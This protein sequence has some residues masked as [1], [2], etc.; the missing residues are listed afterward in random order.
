MQFPNAIVIT[1]IAAESHPVLKQIAQESLERGCHFIVIGDAQSPSD[2]SLAGCD[3]YSLER[4]NQL[5]FKFPR[6]CPTRVYGRKNIGYLIAVQHQSSIIVET[7]DDNIPHDT[8]WHARERTQSVKSFTTAGWVNV[9]RYFTDSAVWPRGFPLDRIQE[10]LAD[11][12]SLP[13]LVADSPIQQGLA[14]EDPD[15][16]AIYRLVISQSTQFRLD[17][18][19]ALLNN[20]WCPFNSQNTTWWKDA[21]P[22]MY[23]P[24]SCSFR[25]TDIWRGFIAQR[26]AWANRW[27]IVFHGPT[28]WQERNQHNL[29]QDFSDELPGYLHNTE[30]CQRLAN[31]DLKPGVECLSDNMR[32]CYSELIN[33][34]LIKKQE[35]VLLDAWL[36]DLYSL[37]R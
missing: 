22:L 31:L 5:G 8:F 14:D 30:I 17:R 7:D 20:A 10:P 28:V 3:F 23:L 16:D 12:N 24:T 26:I 18:K 37:M 11:W 27:S 13:T 1:S 29:M 21:Y 35:L 36:D 4:Q 2:F 25:L 32:L 19:I 33:M 15:V 6:L 9:Y 34:H